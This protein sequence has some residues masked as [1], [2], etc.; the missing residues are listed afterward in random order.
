MEKE[1]LIIYNR[2]EDG[3]DTYFYDETTPVVVKNYTCS[4]QRM[5]VIPNLSATLMFPVCLD[6]YWTGNQY[7]VFQGE[8]Y[9]IFATP[10][11]TK[12][13]S[14][15]RYKHDIQFFSERNVLMGV[16]FFDVADPDNENEGYI[17]NSSDFYFYGSIS[18]FCA[19]LNVSAQYNGIGYSFVVDEDITSENVQIQFSDVYMADALTQSFDKFQIPFYFVGYVCHF[20]FTSNSVTKRFEYGKDKGLLSITKSNANYQIV[21]SCTGIGSENNIPSYYPN[22][23]ED[24]HTF[25]Q[26][27]VLLPKI[28]RDTEGSERFYKALADT[29]VNPDTGLYY[30]FDNLFTEQNPR[31]YKVSFDDIQ[32][33]IEGVTNAAG[34]L[35]GEFAD[36]AYDTNDNDEVDE[37]GNNQHPFFYAKLHKFDGANS[38]NIFDSA[39]A[40]KS[41]SIL[42]KSGKI[43]PEEFEIGI[44]EKTDTATGLVTYENPV[45]V[46]ENGNIVSGNY[47]EKINEGNI[48]QSQQNTKTNEI[49]IALKKNDSTWGIL[50]PNE[51]NNYKPTAGDKFAFVGIGLPQVYIT[52]AEKRLEDEIIKYLV[53]NN[54]EK[55]SFSLKLSS[56]F[57]ERNT[58]VFSQINDN[59]R[60][61]VV[62]DDK[63]YS[64]YVNSYTYKAESTSPFPS[65]EITLTDTL[66]V[67]K[68]SVQTAISSIKNDIM[69]TVGSI[70]FLKQGLKYFIRKD[71]ADFANG[72]ITFNSG[73]RFGKEQQNNINAYGEAS[74]RSLS[75]TEFLEVPLFRYNKTEIFTG[76]QWHAVGGGV[77]ESVTVDKDAEGNELQSGTVTLKIEEGEIGSISEDDLCMGIFHSLVSADNA[78]TD[79]DSR[80]GNFTF[81]GFATSYFRIVEILDERKSMFTYVLRGKTPTWDRQ[82]HPRSSMKFACYSNPTNTSRQSCVYST[83]EYSIG[84]TGMT[85]WEYDSSNIYK[86]SGNLN[87]FFINDK[88]LSGY[89]DVIG[90]GY[91]YG[92][93]DIF[94][95]IAHK[96]TFDTGGDN[97][98]GYG[99]CKEI[100]CHIIDGYG[101]D[102][103]SA[104]KNWTITRE[105]SSAI[106]DAIWNASE[107]AKNF[108][109]KITLCFGEDE[110][111]IGIYDS[112]MFLMSAVN[113]E[114][115]SKVETY[116]KI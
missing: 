38:F 72:I 86:I 65:I 1:H 24:D 47:G 37:E 114:S 76:I 55:F 103:T 12:D 48:Q 5:G 90:N 94:E 107:K 49:W 71:V 17:S 33:T 89:G 13:T 15:T 36:F 28:Y 4:K 40:Q 110:N 53:D 75:L 30:V 9:Y 3:T 35:I 100:E 101:E 22:L 63:E 99:E 69:N 85:T 88:A 60:I 39:I 109:G 2:N 115:G 7:V 8:K 98:I 54:S 93:I 106:D 96:M 66:T 91:F 20:G 59:A 16:Y 23:N 34:Q 95:K 56:V 26:S 31:Q 44:V 79:D 105:T 92:K 61:I 46:D 78:S 87:G 29:Y 6:S 80:N 81:S 67:H 73:I 51:S 19:K 64:F 25:T 97:F 68:N 116:L 108:N 50:M 14:D 77:I 43:A 102:V 83:T 21:A 62:Y 74:L 104:Y 10:T 111:D 42:F 45:Q 84:L 27:K 58:D 18:D 11:S 112:A 82:F 113:N 52:A 70:D 32:P 41:M 57:L